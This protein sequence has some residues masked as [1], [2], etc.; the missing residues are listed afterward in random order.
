[1][2][3]SPQLLSPNERWCLKVVPTRTLASSAGYEVVV[4]A[5]RYEAKG[6]LSNLSD[7]SNL[8][9]FSIILIVIWSDFYYLSIFEK[10]ALR[11]PTATVSPF[12]RSLAPW[13]G[14]GFEIFRFWKFSILKISD[15]PIFEFFLMPQLTCTKF[16]SDRL[17]GTKVEKRDRMTDTQTFILIGYCRSKFVPKSRLFRFCRFRLFLSI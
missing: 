5:L 17:T 2:I 15:F 8:L 6:H 13:F 7:L 3:L 14:A 11:S 1:M 12:G 10:L 4:K 9:K 16:G